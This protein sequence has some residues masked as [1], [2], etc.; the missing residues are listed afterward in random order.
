[1]LYYDAAGRDSVTVWESVCARFTTTPP[2]TAVCARRVCVCE[3]K[4]KKTF[5]SWAGDSKEESEAWEEAEGWVADVNRERKNILGGARRLFESLH[6]MHV[7]ASAS[8]RAC[9][10][11]LIHLSNCLPAWVRAW[12]AQLFKEETNWQRHRRDWRRC[13]LLLLPEKAQNK[14]PRNNFHLTHRSKK[15]GWSTGET[16]D[17]SICEMFT[18]DLVVKVRT[19][20]VSGVTKEKY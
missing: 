20:G 1:M 2:I 13:L 4:G 10:R 3:E 8:V 15:V 19:T 11:S 17:P 14:T 5:F 7:L 9:A 18:L 16:H 6:G 12:V